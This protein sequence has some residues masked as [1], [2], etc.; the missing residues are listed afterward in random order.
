MKTDR[1]KEGWLG[2]VQTVVVEMAD[3]GEEGG[4]LS[5]SRRV[6]L[7]TLTYD[8]QGKRI[9][10]KTFYTVHEDSQEN[11]HVTRH[12][13]EG[14]MIEQTYYQH[15]EF[16]YKVF[17]TYDNKK[18]VEEDFY[19]VMGQLRYTREHKYD[20]HGNPIEMNYS[21]AS[22]KIIDKLKYENEYDAVGNLIKVTT[23]RWV[24]NN[25]GDVYKPVSICFQTITYY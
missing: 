2:P 4:T 22:G 24:T 3:F 7:F 21:E 12:D 8:A 5:L 25:G 10:R 15:G 14:N 9:E 13:T 20:D 18:L 11:L 16:Q 23:S 17:C 19:D 6:K 1:A